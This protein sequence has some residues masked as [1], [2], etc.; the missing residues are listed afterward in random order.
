MIDLVET[1][2]LLEAF[3][4]KRVLIAGDLVLDHYLE[5]AV[6]RISP[7]APVPVVSLGDREPHWIPGG[8]ANVALNVLSLGGVPFLAGVTGADREGEILRELLETAGVDTSSVIVDPCRPTTVKTRVMARNQQLL[9]IDREVTAP[10]SEDITARVLSLMEAV[11]GSYDSV[12]IEDYNKGFLTPDTI[13]AIISWAKDAGIPVSVDPKFD[14]FWEYSGSYLFKPNR[15]E[16]AAALGRVIDS[17]RE[18]VRVC[19]I[20]LERLSPVAVM[21]TLGSDG[22]VLLEKGVKDPFLVPAVA[23][24]VFDVSGAGDSVIAVMG[25][26]AGSGSRLDDAASLA[27]LAAAAVCAEPGVYAVKPGDVIREAGRIGIS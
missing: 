6:S 22:A 9:R 17:P 15:H 12:I 2:R 1:E 26:A 8:A 10:V 4:G 16:A 25:L 5:G 27:G 21:L 20:L 11:S 3:R 14:N 7:E 13:R 24:H 23:R 19:E 18:A